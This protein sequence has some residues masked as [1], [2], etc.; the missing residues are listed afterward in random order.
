MKNAPPLFELARRF[1]EHA[2]GMV[3]PG[4]LFEEFGFN[5]VGPIDGHDLDSLIPTLENIKHLPAREIVAAVDGKALSARAEEIAAGF[6][7]ADLFEY[8][9]LRNVGPRAVNLAGISFVDGID[10]FA[11]QA[12]RMIFAACHAR[13]IPAL[14]AAP[15]GMV[16]GTVYTF[17][18]TGAIGLVCADMDVSNTAFAAAAPALSQHQRMPPSRGQ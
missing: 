3:V 7:D 15:L 13:G 1:E 12:R 17:T 10:F 8:V 16:P 14:T 6:A 2:K 9:E 4:T 18:I 5:Y 11:M